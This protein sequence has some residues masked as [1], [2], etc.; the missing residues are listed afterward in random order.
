[1][2][3]LLVDDNAQYARLLKETL[4]SSGY[5]VHLAE[6][7][8]RGCDTLSSTDI[9]LI[10]SDLKM[11]GLEGLKLHS[12]AR[13]M[14]RYRNTKFLFLSEL[15]DVFRNTAELNSRG[16]FFLDRTT[17]MHAVVKVVD[18]LLFGDFAGKWV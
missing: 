14:E 17:E 1:M 12:F 3:I 7:G 11:P 18:R 16:N 13:E 5:D 8:I 10:I 2:K 4:R 15:K 6:N 9:D